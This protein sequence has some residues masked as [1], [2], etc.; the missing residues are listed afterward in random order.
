ML[1]FSIT[2]YKAVLKLDDDDRQRPLLAIWVAAPAVMGVAYIACF[3]PGVFDPRY[4]TNNF[5][6]FNDFIFINL[7]WFA[8]SLALI[9]G[10]CFYLPY[11]GRMKFDMSYWAGGFPAAALSLVTTLY[12]MLK[13][14]G[15]SYGIAITCLAVASYLNCTFMLQTLAA[16]LRGRLFIPDFK[17]G[18][19]SFM[20]L[21]HEAFRGSIPRLLDAVEA[22]SAGD[23]SPAAADNLKELWR[24]MT[25][26]HDEHSRHEDLVIFKTYHDYFP[27]L[28]Q[29]Y[30]DEHAEHHGIMEKIN[31][32][33]EAVT[34]SGTASLAPMM[35]DYA[36]VLELH[37]R[38]EEDHLVGM[39]RK[40]I[41]LATHKEIIRKVWELTPVETWSEFL[42]WVVNNMP[43]LVQRV[44]FIKTFLWAMP[45]RGQQI[46]IILGKGVDGV[47][48]KRITDELPEII[49]RGAC[50]WE[51]YY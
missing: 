36:E 35:K 42:P 23:S 37:L 30:N 38:G 1:L 12:Y 11:F 32:A 2:F 50:G 9:L 22:V 33:V 16:Q 4:T 3:L 8:V 34:T 10:L 24:M 15:L 31:A 13:P 49:P 45:E 40:Y 19:L 26:A 17:W 28:V 44:R 14:G 7:N 46:G 48:W 25:L 39:P 5:P 43:M 47:Q 27:G 29:P 21:C 51:R 20:R 41:P 18:P 6:T